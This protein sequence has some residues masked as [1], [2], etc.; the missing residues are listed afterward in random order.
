MRLFRNAALLVAAAGVLASC[1]KDDGPT[2]SS[3]NKA[4]FPTAQ[5]S[6]WVYSERAL[7]TN[8][9]E[10]GEA[11]EDS[12]VATGTTSKGNKTAHIYHSFY[13]GQPYDTS[14]Y[15]VEGSKVEQWVNFNIASGI[16]DLPDE[17]AALFAAVQAQLGDTEQWALMADPATATSQIFNRKIDLNLPL[18]GTP[19]TIRDLTINANYSKG[20][21]TSVQVDGKTLN[22]TTYVSEVKVSA[23]LFIGITLPIDLFTVKTEY[24]LVEGVG[25]VQSKTNPFRLRVAV[26]GLGE[27]VNEPFEGSIRT[28]KRYS[29]K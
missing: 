20:S 7:D 4:L 19:A 24:V 28:V 2:D 18:E 16:G 26:T 27:V 11:I 9:V 15:A 10:Y 23:N 14:Y 13:E 6:Y 1:S 8:G 12:V 22:G 5:G 21:A 25:V 17:F 3:G 29:I